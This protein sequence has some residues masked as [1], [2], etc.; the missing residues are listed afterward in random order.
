M[1]ILGISPP[2]LSHMNVHS[3]FPYLQIYKF[4]CFHIPYFRISNLGLMNPMIPMN[5]MIL[6]FISRVLLLQG[7]FTIKIN[8]RGT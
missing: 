6:F 1:S 8:Y 7:L 4:T 2:I 3:V 5:P